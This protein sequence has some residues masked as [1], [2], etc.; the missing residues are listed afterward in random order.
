VAA[1]VEQ[2]GGAISLVERVETAVAEV[3]EAI[4]IYPTIL[5]A[6]Q[7]ELVYSVTAEQAE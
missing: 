6:P 3:A 4:I 7:V 1:G 5:F 2:E